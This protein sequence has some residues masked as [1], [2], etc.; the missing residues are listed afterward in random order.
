MRAR[1]LTTSP[2]ALAPTHSVVSNSALD[3]TPNCATV[4]HPSLGPPQIGSVIRNPE[5]SSL[6]PSLLAAIAD[7]NANTRAALDILLQTVFV[8]TIDAASL[9]SHP[10][11][12]LRGIKSCCALQVR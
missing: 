1:L 11:A 6:V 12:P 5:V 4:P 10:C 9:V 8:N 7:P 3:T 2:H